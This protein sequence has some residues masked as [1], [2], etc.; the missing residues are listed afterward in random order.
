MLGQGPLRGRSMRGS[1]RF[2]TSLHDTRCRQ[3]L[4]ALVFTVSGRCRA[5]WLWACLPVGAGR[6]HVLGHLVA[7]RGPLHGSVAV[8]Q[9]RCGGLRLVGGGA[10]SRNSMAPQTPR[11]TRA[12]AGAK[13]AAQ[14]EADLV[15]T[16]KPAVRAAGALVS[17]AA[18]PLRTAGPR[19]LQRRH[20][21]AGL[22]RLSHGMLL[23]HGRRLARVARLVIQPQADRA[24]APWRVSVEYAAITAERAPAAHRARTRA[25]CRRGGCSRGHDT[26]R[27][28]CGCGAGRR[29]RLASCCG[30]APPKRAAQCRY[31]APGPR[32]RGAVAEQSGLGRRGSTWVFVEAR[33]PLLRA[34]ATTV[35]GCEEV[36][37]L[38]S[39]GKQQGPE[40][41]AA[42]AS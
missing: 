26:G 20:A 36:E 22:A 19:S 39:L 13:R 8:S 23:L 41:R 15:D 9:G 6:Q 16:A 1:M 34:E 35:G 29:T 30:P 11:S 18:C 28:A 2:P 7:R 12:G 37:E 5:G 31:G 14:P 27:R 4:P 25:F 3:A 17:G 32:Q 24:G 33:S 21:G 10:T 42:G 40:R 38:V